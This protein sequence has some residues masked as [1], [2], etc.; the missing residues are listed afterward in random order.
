[1]D[2]EPD[3]ELEMIRADAHQTRANLAGKLEA[4]ESQVSQTVA[5]VT[6]AVETVTTSVTGVTSAVG[7]VAENVTATVAG[8][9]ESVAGTVEAVKESVAST[10]QSVGETFDISGHI[11]KAPW[12]AVGCAFAAGLAGGYAVGGSRSSQAASFFGGAA[13]GA[14]QADATAGYRNGSHTNGRNGHGNGSQEPTTVGHVTD[15]LA[16]IG[17]AVRSLGVSAVM[18]LVSK[19]AQQAVPEAMK[20]DVSGALEKLKTR[21]G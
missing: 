4:L 18:G 13:L 3:R 17:G 6:S 7:Q 5:G 1:M 16:D 21:L 11:Q 19:L 15:T 12:A 20:Q 2:S 8:V 10:M 9:T 14:P